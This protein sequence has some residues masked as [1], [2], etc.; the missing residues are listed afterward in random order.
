MIKSRVNNHIILGLSDLNIERLQKGMA[1]RFNLRDLGP[2][3]PPMEVAIFNGRTEETMYE[4]FKDFITANTEVRNEK[5]EYEKG[6][7]N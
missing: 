4:E 6:K 1:I 2:D 7:K 3:L 5:A